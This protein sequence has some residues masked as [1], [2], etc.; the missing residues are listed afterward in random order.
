MAGKQTR[1][2]CLGGSYDPHYTTIDRS[3]NSWSAGLLVS[4]PLLSACPANA[5]TKERGR[6]HLPNRCVIVKYRRLI[7]C[8]ELRNSFLMS[9]VHYCPSHKHWLSWPAWSS[10]PLT[11]IILIHDIQTPMDFYLIYPD[12]A[13]AGNVGSV[14]L[15]YPSLSFLYISGSNVKQGK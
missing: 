9:L 12:H 14:S 2:N 13:G 4:A 8:L 5:S 3:W 10:F 6:S 7:I 15:V 1:V 11:I